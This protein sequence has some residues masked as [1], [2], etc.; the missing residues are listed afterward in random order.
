MDIILRRWSRRGTNKPCLQKDGCVLDQGETQQYGKYALTVSML[1]STTWM[2]RGNSR[3][4]IWEGVGET[5]EKQQSSRWPLSEV[6]SDGRFVEA[7]ALVEELSNVVAG[8]FQQ[9]IL[10]EELDP[11]RQTQGPGLHTANENRRQITFLK[12]RYFHLPS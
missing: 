11:L 6:I 1:L 5:Q 9:V 10:N 3:Q 4:R 12:N 2:G 7:L 8:V